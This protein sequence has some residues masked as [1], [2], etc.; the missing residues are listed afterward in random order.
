MWRTRR[1][2]FL[3]TALMC[4]VP[5]LV[6]GCRSTGPARVLQSFG[7]GDEPAD[8]GIFT[9]IAIREKLAMIALREMQRLNN[10]PESNR[11]VFVPIPNDP[12]SGGNYFREQRVYDRWYLIDIS[13]SRDRRSDNRPDMRPDR[14]RRDRSK[15]SGRNLV[16]VAYR[17]RLH[18]SYPLPSR[19]EALSTRSMAASQTMDYERYRYVFDSHGEWDGKPG[20]LVK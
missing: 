7:I 18:K 11:V 19:Q 4:I 15:S 5:G 8:D 14:T 1:L 13:K 9:E 17:Y 2:R 20:Q 3:A 6:A 16:T 10:Q 12:L